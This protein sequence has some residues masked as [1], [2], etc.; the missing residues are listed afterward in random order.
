[1]RSLYKT[2]EKEKALLRAKLQ[3]SEEVVGWLSQQL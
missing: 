3:G 1:M 2:C